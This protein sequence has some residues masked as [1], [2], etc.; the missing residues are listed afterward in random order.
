MRRLRFWF[1]RLMFGL[2]MK[3]EIPDMADRY[4]GRLVDWKL[5]GTPSR[6]PV[7]RYPQNKEVVY[8]GAPI[9]V[10]RPTWDRLARENR[11]RKASEEKNRR[12]K[13]RM[14]RTARLTI[15]AIVGF[16]LGFVLVTLTTT[17][18]EGKATKVTICHATGSESNPFVVNSPSAAGVYN[19]HIAHQHAEDIIP[20]FEYKGQTY[21]QNWDAEGQ[22]IWNNGCQVPG[23][24]P[25]PTPEPTETPDKDKKDK[26][27]PTE[28]PDEPLVAPEGT[29]GRPLPFTGI[30]SGTFFIAALVLAGLGG[31]LLLLGRKAN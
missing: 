7:H 31:L 9:F 23:S 17:V 21:S 13:Q 5:N 8:E 24:E 4:F 22:A 18:A 20:P 30:D 3:L 16:V 26:P 25:T 15:A 11:I 29:E 6:K 10:D 27:E 14:S 1:D 12:K 28:T 19:G 2:A